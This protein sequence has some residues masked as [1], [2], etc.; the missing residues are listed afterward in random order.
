MSDEPNPR[1]VLYA[2]PQGGKTSRLVASLKEQNFEQL[3]TRVQVPGEWAIDDVSVKVIGTVL[4]Q[5][6]FE[7]TLGKSDIT[8]QEPGLS[9]GV[10]PS[11]D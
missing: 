8:G 1:R 4:G 5:T 3:V 11:E 6:V 2:G 10:P 9:Q 7:L